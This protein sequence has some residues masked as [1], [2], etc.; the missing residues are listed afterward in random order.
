MGHNHNPYSQGSTLE[1][2]VPDAFHQRASRGKGWEVAEV[3]QDQGKG[4]PVGHLGV[5]ER[6]TVRIP[7]KKMSV[8]MFID[9]ILANLLRD[10]T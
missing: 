2:S 6:C 1:Q 3:S 8:N 4:T 10:D 5:A 9:A 7:E